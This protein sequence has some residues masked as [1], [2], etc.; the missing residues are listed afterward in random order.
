MSGLPNGF[1]WADEAQV[2]EYKRTGS[3]NGAAKL[4]EVPGFTDW[5]GEPETRLAVRLRPP[6]TWADVIS[7]CARREVDPPLDRVGAEVMR[8]WY[9]SEYEKGWRTSRRGAYSRDWDNGTSS[10]AFDDGYLDGNAGRPKWHL[11]YCTD[12]DN[13]GEA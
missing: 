7:P 8:A 2:A 12:H 5:L 4:T 1:H 6:R 3:V 11:T 13:C 10:A 9:V